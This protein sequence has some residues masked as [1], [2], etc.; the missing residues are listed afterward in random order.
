MIPELALF[1]LI[2]ALCLALVMVLLPFVQYYAPNS[3]WP[4]LSRSLSY[5]HGFMVLASFGGLAYAFLSNDFSVA[6]VAQ[7]SYTRLPA[8]YRFCAVWGAHEGSM[9]L[10]VTMLSVWIVGVSAFGKRLPAT[11]LQQVLGVLAAISIGFLL[12]ILFTS[13]PFVRTWPNVPIDG[14]DLNPMLQDFGLSIH[15]PMLYLGYVGFS[16]AFAFAITGL[17]QGRLDRQWVRWTQPWTLAAW[18]FLT[19]GITLGSWWSYRVLGWGGWWFWDPVENASFLPWLLGA[20]LIHSLAITA[21]KDNLK[22]WTVL[23]ALGTFSLSLLGTFLVRSGVLISVHAFAVDPQ[24]GAYILKFLSVVIGG[25]LVLFALRMPRIKQK[26]YYEL[27]SRESFMLINNA[28]LCVAMFT[29]LLGTLYPLALEALHLS[30]ISVGPPYF[31]TLFVPIVFFMLVLMGIVPHT[32]W[33]SSAHAA[34]ITVMV[35]GGVVSLILGIS[36]P[37]VLWHQAFSALN[38]ATTLGAWVTLMTLSGSFKKTIV[39]SSQR[40]S[41]PKLSISRSAMLLAHIGLVVTM[42]GIVFS[43]HLSV[44]RDVRMMPG[45]TAIVGPYHF[46]FDSVT[47]VTGSNFKAQQGTFKV[48][49]KK[50]EAVKSLQAQHRIFNVSQMP[51]A[52]PAIYPSFFYDLY[53]AMSGEFND[54]SWALRLYYKPFIRWI[55]FGGLM[56]ACGAVLGII[57]KII[58]KRNRYTCRTSKCEITG[59]RIHI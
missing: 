44:E 4:H 57:A 58:V 39:T 45:D 19:L 3:L 51:M 7:H 8:L 25:S 15:P 41:W 23:L 59:K 24:R 22:A 27:A 34:L 21:K 49:K 54:G 35:K 20:A 46:Y 43:T 47:S 48:F 1:A 26:I 13:N 55:W 16:V 12:F 53:I 40:V 17:I 56:M 52:T 32:Q 33:Q 18:S 38:V 9:L 50:Q 42:L 28:L 36:V 10:W 11:T 14:N 29:I 30:K 2:L 31:N 37:L 6:Y 5:G